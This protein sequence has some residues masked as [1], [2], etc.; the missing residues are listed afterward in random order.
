VYLASAEV[1]AVASILGKLPTP[2]EYAAYSESINANS[3]DIYRYL[4]FDQL[5]NYEKAAESV[6]M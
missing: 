1:A 6:K 4:N 5:P 3:G 2:A